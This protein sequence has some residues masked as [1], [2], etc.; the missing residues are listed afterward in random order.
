MQMNDTLHAAI[1]IRND[2]GSNL[3]LFH[4]AQRF[5]GQFTRVNRLRV[6]MCMA[7]PAVFANAPAPSR[8]N[9][10]RRSPSLNRPT[11]FPSS[12]TVVIPRPLRDIS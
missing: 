6:A 12:T 11:S 4:T 10:R 8:S 5:G 2:Q 3:A 7:S 1:R 9:R